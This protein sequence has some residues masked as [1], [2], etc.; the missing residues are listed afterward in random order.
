MYTTIMQPPAVPNCGNFLTTVESVASHRHYHNHGHHHMN[1]SMSPPMAMSSASSSSASSSPSPSTSSSPTSP[2]LRMTTTTTATA[3]ST[4]QM[5]GN[6]SDLAKDKASSPPT[7]GTVP[8]STNLPSSPK[9]AALM[10]PKQS[11]LPTLNFPAP[12]AASSASPASALNLLE[13]YIVKIEDE[14]DKLREDLVTYSQFNCVL[15]NMKRSFFKGYTSLQNADR[16]KNCR[17]NEQKNVQLR[18]AVQ[19]AEM[20]LSVWQAQYDKLVNNLNGENLKSSV[21]NPVEAFLDNPLRGLNESIIGD[22]LK[23][24]ASTTPTTNN[25]HSTTALFNLAAGANNVTKMEPPHSPLGKPENDSSPACKPRRSSSFDSSH[26]SLSITPTSNSVSLSSSALLKMQQGEETC[27][28]PVTNGHSHQNHSECEES[29]SEEEGSSLPPL[30]SA[31]S[32]FNSGESPETESKKFE[33][34]TQI[35]VHETKVVANQ[36]KIENSK[37]DEKGECQKNVQIK[38]EKEDEK[39]NK[40]VSNRFECEWPQCDQLFDSEDSLMHHRRCHIRKSP[41]S[42]ERCNSRML[43]R[44]E[45]DEHVAQCKGKSVNSVKKA[46][47]SVTDESCESVHSDDPLSSKEEK[48]KSEQSKV[49]NNNKQGDKRKRPSHEQTESC[50]SDEEIEVEELPFFKSAFAMAAAAAAAAA[51]QNNSSLES[52]DGKIKSDHQQRQMIDDHLRSLNLTAEELNT[53]ARYSELMMYPN[54]RQKSY[55]ISG[56]SSSAA[57]ASTFMPPPPP[58]YPHTTCQNAPNGA[59]HPLF[60][61]PAMSQMELG[62]LIESGRL[63]P[64]TI[65]MLVA[66]QHQ[67]H[68]VNEQQQRLQ[69]Y[70]SSQQQNAVNASARSLLPSLLT[71][72]SPPD[73]PSR[74]PGEVDA[75][76]AENLTVPNSSRSASF[77]QGNP[78][79]SSVYNRTNS[80]SGL[81]NL[82]KTLSASGPSNRILSAALSPGPCGRGR[83]SSPPPPLLPPSMLN[84]GANGSGAFVT[85][86]SNNGFFTSPSFVG[87]M[88]RS[89]TISTPGSFSALA[90]LAATASST[91]SSAPS[92]GNCTTSTTSPSNNFASMLTNG[93]PPNVSLSSFHSKGSPFSPFDLRSPN[94]HSPN[95]GR[96]SSPHHPHHRNMYN[97]PPGSNALPLGPMHPMFGNQSSQLMIAAAAAAAADNV[98]HSTHPLGSGGHMGGGPGSE[99]S[100]LTAAALASLGTLKHNGAS[101][102]NGTGASNGFMGAPPSSGTEYKRTRYSGIGRYRCPWPDCGYTPHFLRDLRRHMFK[103][104][105]DKKHKCDFPGCDFVSVW[106]TSLLQHQRKKHYG[107]SSSIQLRSNNRNSNT[108]T[109]N[110]SEI[111]AAAAAAAASSSSNGPPSM[112]QR[113]I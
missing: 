42:C 95:G 60:S 86:T 74:S 108:T 65:S 10:A 40:E 93:P 30:I 110:F 44:Q 41:Y 73:S 61:T 69:E 106:K 90:A 12:T 75:A 2:D 72:K 6:A 20:E 46:P 87:G 16:N 99:A 14:K 45:L 59:T 53:Y 94:R 29:T 92:S 102:G 19:E 26:R 62:A 3:S 88:S 64:M 25:N 34:K 100:R 31:N 68:Q 81:I 101:P 38:N 113:A 11:N 15:E 85:P 103:H 78:T 8:V 107:V 112:D 1:D 36:M 82:S 47:E 70:F 23:S 71:S 89:Y 91:P 22:S 109:V 57:T 76:T 9:Q 24:L 50:S 37:E 49:P 96:S 63:S 39:L 67:N 80:V 51:A 111:A 98:R 104:T 43:S 56:P 7:T 55:T 54:K 35:D 97:G 83:S 77:S 17:C 84:G 32:V 28:R 27:P 33:I 18:R 58:W 105:G 48:H 21:T 52:S 5:N 13:H 4:E 79:M 66:Q